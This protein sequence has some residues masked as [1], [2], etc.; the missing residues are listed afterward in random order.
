MYYL[1][2]RKSLRQRGFVF[3]MMIWYDKHHPRALSKAL[4][5]KINYNISHD[6][7]VVCIGYHFPKITFPRNFNR[8]VYFV[9]AKFHGVVEFINVTFNKEVQFSDTVF[10]VASKFI[11]NRFIKI[12]QFSNIKFNS[13]TDFSVLSSMK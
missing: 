7:A 4:I 12:V 13:F 1:S 2:V 3:I 6:E 11:N 9:N 8:P 5:D 10:D